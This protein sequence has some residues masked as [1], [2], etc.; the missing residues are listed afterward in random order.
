MIRFV[1]QWLSLL[2]YYA[3]IYSATSLYWITRRGTVDRGIPRHNTFSGLNFQELRLVIMS[4]QKKWHRWCACSPSGGCHIRQVRNVSFKFGERPAS[5]CILNLEQ[6]TV[7]CMA[8][9]VTRRWRE[10]L[11]VQ[12]ASHVTIRGN[13]RRIYSLRT[14][15]ARATSHR[16][17]IKWAS[18]WGCGANVSTEYAAIFIIEVGLATLRTQHMTLSFDDGRKWNKS[19]NRCYSCW[20]REIATSGNNSY[21][22]YG[23][24][25]SWGLHTKT[26][27]FLM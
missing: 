9:R 13:P 8:Q 4:L 19:H 20:Q 6:L 21:L 18:C 7:G 17:G 12:R 27:K 5:R 22:W 16:E 3:V 1:Y 2:L 26:F 25:V 11:Q 14:Q 10:D 15:V 23:T 24:Q